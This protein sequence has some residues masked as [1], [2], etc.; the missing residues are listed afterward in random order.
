MSGVLI[1]GESDRA[2]T[3]LRSG[4]F[5]TRHPVPVASGN[6][7]RFSRETASLVPL[8]GDIEC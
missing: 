5:L 1:A 3:L 8:S 6:R 7:K 4:C 2:M